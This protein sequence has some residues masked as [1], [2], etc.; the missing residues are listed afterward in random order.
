ME[1]NTMKSA[2]RKLSMILALALSILM[3]SS[4]TPKAKMTESGPAKATAYPETAASELPAAKSSFEMPAA[5]AASNE[6]PPA[7]NSTASTDNLSVKD[8]PSGTK[9]MYKP[10]AKT[11]AESIHSIRDYI[12]VSDP[13]IFVFDTV[14]RAEGDYDNNYGPY[15]L[16]IDGDGDGF[17]SSETVWGPA[18]FDLENQTVTVYS[19]GYSEYNVV[20]FPIQYEKGTFTFDEDGSRIE[21]KK[22]GYNYSDYHHD[23]CAYWNLGTSIELG[24]CHFDI[25]NQD[26]SDYYS[27][28]FSLMLR[29]TGTTTLQLREVK[30]CLKDKNGYYLV[31][32]TSICYPCDYPIRP[33]EEFP[34]FGFAQ[35]N[36]RNMPEDRIPK[37]ADDLRI[38]IC[39][40][41]D[42]DEYILWDD[43]PNEYE[44]TELL[45]YDFPVNNVSITDGETRVSL[46][47]EYDCLPEIGYT[48]IIPDKT[49]ITLYDKD[50]TPLWIFYV[51]DDEVNGTAKTQRIGNTISFDTTAEDRYDY[52]CV[53]ADFPFS[54]A[55]VAGYT[56]DTRSVIP[57]SSL[58]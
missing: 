7:A 45:V 55:D 47:G 48:G 37:S 56:I 38:G 13:H 35:Y 11:L 57:T 31:T 9:L 8:I 19:T 39:I 14:F 44:S 20:T 12:T 17:L 4:C 10:Q 22:T 30:F 5:K 21:L 23:K 18:K 24:N 33:G 42:D 2:F 34:V 25:V 29:N 50:R 46:H 40:Y 28:R 41:P 32:G 16:F 53:Y 1:E 52:S 54:A 51:H 15:S 58:A 27:V 6:M 49:I 3:L 26:S 43:D 36:T